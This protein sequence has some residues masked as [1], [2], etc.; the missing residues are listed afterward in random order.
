MKFH[1]S[2]GDLVCVKNGRR[3]RTVTE[4]L[5][6]GELVKCVTDDGTEGIFPARHLEL[7][8]RPA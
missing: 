4:V 8:A 7:I 3:V 1:F 6:L 2:P 5:M